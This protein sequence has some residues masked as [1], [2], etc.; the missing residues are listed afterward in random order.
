M[1]KKRKIIIT[2]TLIIAVAVLLGGF[3]ILFFAGSNE[4]SRRRQFISIMQKKEKEFLPLTNN[5]KYIISG[6]IV[7]DN[8]EPVNNVKVRISQSFPVNFGLKNKLKNSTRVVNSNFEITLCGG[9]CVSLGFSKN[10]YHSVFNKQ[11]SV[12][13]P[14]GEL[15]NIANPVKTLDVKNVKIILDKV[16]PIAKIK[17]VRFSLFIKKECYFTSFSVPAFELSKKDCQYNNIS[18]LNSGMIY[19]DFKRNKAGKMIKTKINN[20]GNGRL[21]PATTYLK[22]IGGEDC[23]FKLFEGD[24]R[25][26]LIG[27]KE[28][29]EA[30]YVK[31]LVFNWPKDMRKEIPFYYKFGKIY[32]KGIMNSASCNSSGKIRMGFSFYQNIETNSDPMVRRNLRTK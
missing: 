22:M 1:N 29:P 3:L 16:G 10:G 17:K 21:G 32:G 27:I 4:K 12:F 7:D 31:Q 30:G 26:N 5:S 18:S 9:A 2:V 13:R 23:G 25:R 11:F 28:A 15:R 6:I 19:L 24:P 20:V 8:G 14:K